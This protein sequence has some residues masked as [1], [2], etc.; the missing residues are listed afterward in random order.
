MFS[1]LWISVYAFYEENV[2]A[3]VWLEN[4]KE[5]NNRA[6]SLSDHTQF[7]TLHFMH[8]IQ[9]FVDIFV[10]FRILRSK[11][12]VYQ[13][14][15][16]GRDYKGSFALLDINC[17]LDADMEKDYSH[18][19]KVEFGILFWVTF[20]TCSASAAMQVS[21]CLSWWFSHST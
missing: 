8:F 10:H 11:T 9:G 15:R 20:L 13:N 12:F 18:M 3:S 21:T 6:Y 2:L 7:Q 5:I 17:I 14:Q 4:R 1:I 19:Q 16:L